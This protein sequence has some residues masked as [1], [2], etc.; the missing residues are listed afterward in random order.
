[1]N[2]LELNVIKL[3]DEISKANL[4]RR[5][6]YR[7][8]TNN[9]GKNFWG[10]SWRYKKELERI[11]DETFLDNSSPEINISNKK[12]SSE[13]PREKE[14]KAKVKTDADKNVSWSIILPSTS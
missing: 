14:I 12:N 2:S 10:K 7:V 5:A 8:L 9:Y 4:K 13:K 6:F 3:N 11:E 1:M